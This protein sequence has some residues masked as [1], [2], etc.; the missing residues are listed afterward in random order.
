[1]PSMDA[2]KAEPS[3]QTKA[4]A[5]RFTWRWK[6]KS[7]PRMWSPS[8]FISWALAMAVFRRLT[9]RGYSART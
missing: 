4:P 6:E 3:P 8:R 5:P 2:V 1:M 9:A 7:V